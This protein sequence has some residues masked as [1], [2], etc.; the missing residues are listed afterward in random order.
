MSKSK[1]KKDKAPSPKKEIRN[2]I[3]DQL[4]NA[5]A[6]LEEKLGKEEFESRIKKA[7]KMLSAGIKIKPAK[8]VKSKPV[9][10]DNSVTEEKAE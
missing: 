10:K 6:S 8:P 7:A 1:T 3:T 4:K 2:Q 5:L 9:K